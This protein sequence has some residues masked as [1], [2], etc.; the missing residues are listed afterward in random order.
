MMHNENTFPFL[1]TDSKDVI[2][3]EDVEVT[4][5][6]NQVAQRVAANADVVRE[7]GSAGTA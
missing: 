4:D 6:H 3:S 5:Q 2:S 1:Y 7:D